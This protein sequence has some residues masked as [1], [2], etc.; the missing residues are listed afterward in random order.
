MMAE[1][2]KS[3]IEGNLSHPRKKDYKPCYRGGQTDTY[4]NSLI[5][6]SI[7]DLK[8]TLAICICHRPVQF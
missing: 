6:G 7:G 3:T 1:S 4:V 5:Q 8:Q 2:W